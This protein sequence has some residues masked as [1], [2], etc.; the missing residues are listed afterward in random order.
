ME[1]FESCAD[2]LSPELFLEFSLP[3]LTRISS[4][5]KAVFPEI[6]MTVFPRG[7]NACLANVA[8]NGGYDV[9]AVDWRISPRQARE[10]VGP[11]VTLQV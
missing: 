5:V 9:I 7:A 11:D 10:I 1:V 4:E 6:P 3:Y 2:C 8:E